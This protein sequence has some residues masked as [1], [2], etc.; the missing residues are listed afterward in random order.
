MSGVERSDA[1]RVAQDWISEHYFTTDSTTESFKA[2]VLAQRKAWDE[3]SEHGTPRTRLTAE[4]R[5]L[6]KEMVALAGLEDQAARAEAS[7]V[8][9]AKLAEILGF[10]GP[11][12]KVED[13][14]PVRIL[15]AA[16]LE[17]PAIAI[18]SAVAPPVDADIDPL[19]ALLAK[20]APTLSE[21]FI[22][23]DSGD[24]I[25]SVAR[26]LSALFVSGDP[27]PA[28][29]L[30][31]AGSWAILAERERWPEGRYLAVDLQLVLERFDDRRGGEFDRALACLSADALA[32]DAEGAIWW[33]ATLEESARHTV[34]VSKD[35]REGIRESIEIIAN[36]VVRRRAAQGLEALPASEAQELA[37]QSL[38][39]LYRILFLLYAEA[40]PELE[41]LP[42]RA[43]EY[44]RGYSLDRLRDLTLV[45]LATPQALEGTHLYES[46][47]TLFR[48]VDQGHEPAQ[49]DRLADGLR[50]QPLRAD[51]FR[52][53]ATAHIDAVGLGN[54]AMQRVL[55]HLLLSKASGKKDRG[56]ISYAELGINQLGAVYEGLMSYTG[57]FAEE[58]LYEVA[59]NRDP[60]K[61]SW[62]V[63]VA[64]FDEEL[65]DHLVLE[66]AEHTGEVRPV[67]HRKGSFVYRLSGRDRQQSASYYT[68]EVLTRF[69]VSQAL[70][71]LLVQDGHTTTAEEILEL[72]ICEPAL[73]SGAFAIEAVRQ[74]AEEYLR[75]RQKELEQQIDPD[76]YARELQRVKAYLALHQVYGV[77]LNPTAVELAEISL[78]LDTMVAGL[79]APWFGLRLRAGNSL[80]GAQRA[81]YSTAQ[82]SSKRWLAEAPTKVGSGP[83]ERPKIAGAIPHFLLPAEGW[84]AAAD[85]GKE[86][87]ELAPDAVTALKAWRREVRKKPTKKQLDQ[88]VDLG[89]RVEGLWALASRRLSI[90]QEQTRRAIPLWGRDTPAEAPTTVTREQI[91]TSLANPDGA[92]RR[93]RRV[94]D[95]WCALWFWPL[96]EKEIVPPTLDAWL[97][98]LTLLLGQHDRK[99]EAR[100]QLSV[101]VGE[102]WSH[103][104]TAEQAYLQ[105]AGASPVDDVLARH[106]WLAVCERVVEEQRFFHWQLEFGPLF[107]QRGGFDLQVGNPPWVR[108]RS[109]VEVLLAE[110][111]PW[112]ALTTKA[113]Q[114]AKRERKEATLELS[115]M[116]DVVIG[117]TADVGVVAEF[118]GWAGAYPNLAGLQPNLYRCFMDRTWAHQSA[119]GAIALIHPETH[120]TDDK[121]QMLRAATYR[122]LRRHW[123]FTNGLRLFEIDH[124]K[125]Y[126]VH[127]YAA[128]GDPSFLTASMLYHPDTVE[129]SLRHDGSGEQ[130]GLKD[131]DGN[132]D[133][134]PHKARVL[135]VDEAMLRTWHALLEPS[136]TPVGETRQVYTV[137]SDVAEVLAT[138][139]RAERIGSL[140]TQYSRGW[141]E[142]IDRQKGRF[143]V[144][145]GPAPTWDDVILQGPHLFVGTPFYKSPNE[146]MANQMDWSPVDLETLP[147]DAV[148][149]TAYKPVGDRATYDAAYTHWKLPDGTVTS[150]RDHYRV[151][152]RTM[153]APTGERSLIPAVIPPGASHVDGV[154]SVALPSS[155][156]SL[157]AMVQGIAGSIIGDFSI[158][159]VPK[160]HVRG[161]GFARLPAPASDSLCG[162]SIG[163]RAAALVSLTEAFAQF[164]SAARAA[165]EVVPSFAARAGTEGVALLS[166]TSDGWT[167]D[168]PLRIARDRRQ[169]LLEIDVLVAIGLGVT[170][171]QLCTIYRTQ[172]P[173]LY[174][175]DRN[176]DYYDANGRLVPNSVLTVWRKKGDA[177]TKEER[178][179][180]N[181][182]GN[183]YVYELPYVTL[184]READMRKAY[185]HFEQ[186]LAEHGD[187]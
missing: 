30:V 43:P 136:E 121:A 125:W 39:F 150:A 156:L 92:Y 35:L 95:A 74:L 22:D 99:G 90:A 149:T 114:G 96:T 24:E 128:A 163:A 175:Y 48:L 27:R 12:Q 89:K 62:V 181:A 78:W 60:E 71:E 75:R 46:L 151:A 4:R 145:W 158:R 130:P 40:S 50:F 152:W 154:F 183:T 15:T 41:V 153:I 21:P 165:S 134:R 26:V 84:G 2:R 116:R 69:V 115:G 56:F 148:P 112:W 54:G 5:G 142:S 170:I 137:N 29:A 161:S 93:L 18:V 120:L 52:P 63:P 57:F 3:A 178:T 79:Q 167:P 176:R 174:G 59:K 132:W 185:A 177:I 68:P 1:I 164:W 147:P 143:D 140:S 127:V 13:R 103:L 104:G 98:A 66:T 83:Q 101:G 44:E 100:G 77:D 160:K 182:S 67:V 146:T 47:A 123:Q 108:P 20:N 73:G 42:V 11:G 168:V 117:A 141:D 111:D 80:I 133:L 32:P 171:D 110:G 85:V 88:L 159:S 118:L 155:E 14:G 119:T 49:A 122:R 23:A 37:K 187:G 109:D 105:F 135:H 9:N 97:D 10:G 162:R 169:A 7:G 76:D 8:L 144:H 86:I 166:L 53:Q 138:L 82:V 61:G 28:F 16:G 25:A 64:R 173:V 33:T 65:R 19:D 72:T 157:L 113:T 55:E 6:L 124:K 34:G 17:Q 184:D 94:M 31:L 186:V 81:V 179:A 102:T 36:E 106:P 180:T 45:E 126:G 139:A 131:P 129:R 87:K 58:D 172:F 38:R 107:E 91:E 70:E 51:L